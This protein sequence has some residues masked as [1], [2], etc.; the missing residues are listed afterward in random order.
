[1]SAIDQVRNRIMLTVE[2]AMDWFNK[3]TADRKSLIPNFSLAPLRHI[4]HR[5]PEEWLFEQHSIDKTS[6]RVEVNYEVDEGR[7]KIVAFPQQQYEVLLMKGVVAGLSLHYHSNPTLKI[8]S[9]TASGSLHSLIGD[10]LASLYIRE[11]ALELAFGRGFRIAQGIRLSLAGYSHLVLENSSA[12]LKGWG[13]TCFFILKTIGTFTSSFEMKYLT[14]LSQPTYRYALNYFTQ[15][16]DGEYMLGAG[17]VGNY[18]PSERLD[19]S[20]LLK[21]L[22][23]KFGFAYYAHEMEVLLR[24]YVS[25]NVEGCWNLKAR[26]DRTFQKDVG[27]GQHTVLGSLGVHIHSDVKCEA[28]H[29]R[30][31]IALEV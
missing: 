14:R 30:V 4:D 2:D 12:H 1:M 31:F 26:L 23:L 19:V 15:Q 20:T 27:S 5:M 17:I 13:A 18:A 10:G 28:F 16:S 3:I 7:P 29:P 21:G 9:M 22:R 25:S 11:K 8:M 6:L 24:T